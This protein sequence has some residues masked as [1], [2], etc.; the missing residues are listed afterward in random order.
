MKHILLKHN[1]IK[2]GNETIIFPI[3]T[4]I[5][6]IEYLTNIICFKTSP[7]EVGLDWS[8]KK[9]HQIW[10][11]RCLKNPSELFC[12]NR[13]GELIWKLQY[14]NVVGFGRIIPE[15]KKEE[16]FISSEHYKKY[17]DK[18][19]GKELLEVYAGNF[20]LIVDANTGYIYDKKESR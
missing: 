9:T 12:Y 13:I 4:T 14:D 11:E 10:K 20:R 16:D 2:I 17:I 3:E 1:K 5:D 19:S 18:Y 6:K 8:N 7:S 15:L